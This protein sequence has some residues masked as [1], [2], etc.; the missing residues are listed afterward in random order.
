[1]IKFYDEIEN[2]KKILYD[3]ST[4]G[5]VAT[6]IQDAIDE[7]AS[8]DGGGTAESV[9][10]DNSLTT[11][12]AMNVQDAIDEICRNLGWLLPGNKGLFGGGN[13]GSFQDVMDYIDIT[14]PSNAS[15]FGDLTV[16]REYLAGV[17]NGTN[18][19]GVFGGGYYTSNILDYINIT[20]LGNASD[21]GDLTVAR[22]SLAGVDNGTNNRGVF[23]GGYNGSR[24][25]VMDY[26]DI[27]T[28]SNASDFGDL[29]VERNG[30]AGVEN[31]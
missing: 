12:S 31:S 16:A 4:S 19:R 14:T 13:D 20:V 8:S 15:D 17:D 11:L 1:M 7:L 2:A 9:S 30:L 21:F 28:P 24:L 3:N 25:N 27:T 5:L 22:Y 26:I 10:Y 6:N 18:N 23:G 29:T